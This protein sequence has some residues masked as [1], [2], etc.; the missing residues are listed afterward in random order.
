MGFWKQRESALRL[1]WGMDKSLIMESNRPSF[2]GEFRRSPIDGEEEEYF[3]QK[4]KLR[5]IC[6]S[7]SIVLLMSVAV[8]GVIAA[9]FIFRSFMI[10]TMHWNKDVAVYSSSIFAA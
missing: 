1:K 5:R 8:I 7:H 10:Y 3:S 2:R 4:I 9:I 6:Y